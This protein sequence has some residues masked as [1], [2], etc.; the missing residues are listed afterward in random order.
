MLVLEPML[1]VNKL[2]DLASVLGLIVT[3]AGFIITIIMLRRSKRA[4]EQTRT[5]VA[6]VRQRLAIRAAIL[7]LNRVISDVEELKPLHRAAAWEVLPGRYSSLRRQLL[8]VKGLYP[9]LSKAQKTTIQGVI[10][11]FSGI[12]QIVETALAA[13][14]SPPDIVGL[15]RIAAEQGDKLN[16]VLIA[17]QAD[18]KGLTL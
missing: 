7:D 9:K 15:N 3:T 18:D 16:A 2:A 14:E 1:I 12:E 5:A 6:E 4:A 10:Q 8:A 11:Q 17:I 13:N